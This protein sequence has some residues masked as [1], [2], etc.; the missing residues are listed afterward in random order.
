MKGLDKLETI[1]QHN[2][3]K[4]ATDFDYQFNLA[5]GADRMSAHP[6]LGEIRAIVDAETQ[7]KIDEQ[8]A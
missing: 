7:A 3:G 5:Y 1:I 2:Q 6:L 8:K 4:N